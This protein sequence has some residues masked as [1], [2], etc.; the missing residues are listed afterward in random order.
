M[1]GTWGQGCWNTFVG[2]W[3]SMCGVMRV[4]TQGHLAGDGGGGVRSKMWK[5][6][7]LADI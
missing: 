5:A 1:T 6:G 3:D 2:M 7:K 4:G